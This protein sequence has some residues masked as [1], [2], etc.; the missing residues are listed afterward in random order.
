MNGLGGEVCVRIGEP[1]FL[2]ASR[3]EPGLRVGTGN[4]SFKSGR[5][6]KMFFFTPVPLGWQP[7]SAA[8]SKEKI[9]FSG[10]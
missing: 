5:K 6:C 2:E 3:W 4:A 7:L 8:E 9:C 1:G 10:A